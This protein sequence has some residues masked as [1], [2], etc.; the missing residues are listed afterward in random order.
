MD[1]SNFNN[2]VNDDEALA[3]IGEAYYRGFGM[4]RDFNQAFRFYRKAA[5]LGNIAALRRMGFCYE[6]G[7]GT[8]RDLEAALTCYETAS[9]KGDAMATLKIG[10]FY[11]DGLKKLIT[12]DRAKA[13]DYYLAALQ[14]AKRNYDVWSAADIYLRV[15]D[16]LF[17]GIGIER[18]VEAAYDFYTAAADL[19]MERIDSGDSESEELLE[20]AE[21][22]IQACNEELGYDE[23]EISPEGFEA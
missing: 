1:E 21:Q 12:I 5:D 22:G 23:E 10:D 7:H 3:T 18:D 4:K 14:Q 11:R 20:E 6:L 17:K 8:K 9:E 16:V 15:G 19:F 2:Q 13:T